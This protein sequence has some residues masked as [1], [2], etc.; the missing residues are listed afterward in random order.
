MLIQKTQEI[1]NRQ[2]QNRPVTKEVSVLL[3]ALFTFYHT[4]SHLLIWLAFSY[5]FVNGELVLLYEC[6]LFI[7]R[8]MVALC[9]RTP[10]VKPGFVGCTRLLVSE[11]VR[12]LTVLMTSLSSAY[13]AFP[14][15]HYLLFF[16]D[17]LGN[18][19]ARS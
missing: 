13:S 6:V 18:G 9:L 4:D 8:T 19:Y 15:G 10:H 3:F 11:F 5:F 1:V 7:L 2:I 14:L 16:G 17:A 12:V